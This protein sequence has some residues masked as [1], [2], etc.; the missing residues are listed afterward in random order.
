MNSDGFTINWSSADA[1]ARRVGWVALG[2]ANCLLLADHDS[3]Q[4][5]D[6]FTG[7]SSITDILFQFKLTR[8]GTVTV[9]DVRAQYTTGSGVIDG[10]ITS[11]ELWEDDGDGVF[12]TGQDTQL[13]N[14]VNGAS[15]QLNF[16]GLSFSPGTGG[17]IYFVRATV[18]SIDPGDSTTFSLGAADIDSGGANESGTVS[19]VTHKQR[20]DCNTT[21]R[22]GSATIADGSSSTTGTISPA[23]GDIAN[24]FVVFGIRL[25]NADPEN[26][27][28]TGQ[29]TNTTTVTFERDPDNGTTGDVIIEWYVTEFT[30][31]VSVQRGQRA[32]SSPSGTINLPTSVDPSKSFPLISYRIKGLHHDSDD[33][34]RARIIN[35]G[36]DLELTLNSTPTDGVNRPGFPG[37]SNS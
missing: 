8:T 20:E 10:D 27:Q 34:V 19:N 12:E 5:T 9:T 24:A 17:T 28:V 6:K 31:G 30:S 14:S 1:T 29:I 13:D 35:N 26:T 4:V 7:L 11:G 15:N 16:T 21:V 18:S 3:G 2:C 36:D 32:M 25:D 23:L 22:S 33:F 37:D